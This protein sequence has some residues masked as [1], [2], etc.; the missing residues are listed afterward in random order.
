MIL[1]HIDQL[2]ISDNDAQ[3][4]ANELRSL[5]YLSQGLFFLNHQV[6]EIEAEVF[7]R[8]DPN[9]QFTL[10]GNAPWLQDVP[11]GLIA[12]SFHW[13][14]VSA[15][16]LVR[17]IGWLVHGQDKKKARA[18]VEHVMPEVKLWRDKIGAHFSLVSP[19][20]SDN[21]ADLAMSVMFPIEFHDRSF[22]TSSLSLSL[23]GGGVSHTSRG[24]MTWSLTETHKQLSQ[25][26]W[27]PEEDEETTE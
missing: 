16:N 23:G 3:V 17:L 27:P 19:H 25:R 1:D 12:C 18:Y 26:F 6:A 11:M 22:Q 9:R 15:C 13:Y 21:P 24:G 10:M 2:G 7:G 14:A 8:L 20:P 5:A 4:H